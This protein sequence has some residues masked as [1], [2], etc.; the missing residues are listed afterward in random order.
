MA[1][2]W[3]IREQRQQH[4]PSSLTNTNFPSAP[5]MG[6]SAML[7]SIT[8]SACDGQMWQ[9]QGSI[10]PPSTPLCVWCQQVSMMCPRV[11]EMD[12]YLGCW[13]HI[14]QLSATATFCTLN[15]RGLS[16]GVTSAVLLHE[17]GAEQPLEPA[18]AKHSPLA[19][20]GPDCAN[21]GWIVMLH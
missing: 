9:T 21:V 8:A 19:R 1:G 16:V 6:C 12:A 4:S 10:W 11:V 7:A 5:G 13:A 17:R 15:A 3:S 14:V 18:D 2:A 20:P